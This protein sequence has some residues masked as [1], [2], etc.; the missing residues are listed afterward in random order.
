[1]NCGLG[2]WK[3]THSFPYLVGSCATFIWSKQRVCLI[4]NLVKWQNLNFCRC[5]K[6]PVY[7]E[8]L[9]HGRWLA[10]PPHKTQ[11]QVIKAAVT[12]EKNQAVLSW[13]WTVDAP[14]ERLGMPDCCWQGS[15]PPSAGWDALKLMAHF[16]RNEACE[17]Q[18]CMNIDNSL[19]T[20]FF[21]PPLPRG[22]KCFL[23]KG[24]T[25]LPVRQEGENFLLF[26]LL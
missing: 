24:G 18:L 17:L 9:S 16:S 12:L 25:V 15:V 3:L 2:I 22:V 8:A 21:P 14:R 1:M 5:L 11:D 13:G 23:S 6:P 4:L 20:L 7:T 19:Q 26:L 10:V